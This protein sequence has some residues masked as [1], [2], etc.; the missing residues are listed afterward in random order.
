MDSPEPT[1]TKLGEAASPDGKRTKL[2]ALWSD[3]VLTECEREEVDGTEATCEV[4]A[5]PD[6]RNRI[7]FHVALGF[8]GNMGWKIRVLHDQDVIE[9]KAEIGEIEIKR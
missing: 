1:I 4:K 5:G 2:I 6:P 9:A 7:T 3:N 8:W